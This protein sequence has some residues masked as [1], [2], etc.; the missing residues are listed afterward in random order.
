MRCN[1]LVRLFLVGVVSALPSGCPE[2][3][4]VPG[5]LD[6][7]QADIKTD[8]SVLDALPSDAATDTSPV[9]VD[10]SVPVPSGQA[11]AAIVD[12]PQHLITGPKADG[13]VGDVKILNARVAFIIEGLRRVDGYR[14]YGGNTVDMV[15][16]SEDG[17]QLYGDLFGE[18]VQ[19]WNLMIFEPLS[20]TVVD[21]GTSGGAARVRV[22][23]K[24]SPFIFADSFIRAFINPDLAELDIVHDYVLEPDVDYLRHEVRVANIGS[25]LVRIDPPGFL[26]NQGDGLFHF[27]RGSGFSDASGPVDYLAVGG[28]Q[29]AVGILTKDTT[30]DFAFNYSNVLLCLEENYSLAPGE[31]LL[32]TYFIGVSRNGHNGL[33]EIA[34]EL[35]IGEARSATIEGTV[36]LPS[37][38]S[39]DPEIMAQAVATVWDDSGPVTMAPI[40]ADGSFRMVV[41][42]G[43]YRVEVYVPQHAVPLAQDVDTTAGASATTTWSIDPA[44]LIKATIADGS[45]TPVDARVMAFADE[46]TPTPSP[47]PPEAV[48]V[49][50]DSSWQWGGGEFGRVSAV[51]YGIGG[52]TTLKVPAGTYVVHASRGFNYETD[53]EQVVVE[54]GVET[55]VALNISKVVDT[56]GTVSGDFHIHALRSPDSNVP[57]H[58]RALQAATVEMEAPPL[59][60]HVTLASLAPAIEAYGL[61]DHVIAVPGQEVTTFEFGHFNSFPLEYRELEPNNGAV[62]PYDKNPTT[63]FEAIRSQGTYQPFIQVNH[64]RGSAISGYFDYIGFDAVTGE[65]SRSGDAYSTNFDGIEVFNG[66]CG[67]SAEFDDW[68]AMTNLGWRKALSSG[69][70]SHNERGVI[71]NPRQVTF[72]EAQEVRS[73]LAVYAEALRKRRSFVT[74]GPFV[75][76][77]TVDE[78]A[79]MGDLAPVDND[80]QVA[81]RVQVS[82]PSW[83]TLTDVRL[84]RN[85]EVVDIVPIVEAAGGVRLDATLTDTPQADAWYMIHVTGSGDIRPVYNS[86]AP[87]AFTNPI[88][89]DAD[90]D[91]SWT[92]PGL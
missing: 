21:D 83:Q 3:P 28:A 66:S 2:D 71:G 22:E 62:F 24:A 59:T 39:D 38:A 50:G 91:G 16:L 72:V 43:S 5:P 68:V 92:P 35:T 46:S 79:G 60:E 55:A 65:S 54:A 42:P 48:D 31:E 4:S 36:T 29:Q 80:G 11:R 41:V 78:S 20:I 75:R 15:A 26:S 25:E 17:Q 19:T 52:N 7:P 47:Y 84:M 33:E 30:L 88:E 87:A 90:G 44:A 70:D 61:S 58:I 18:L 14:Y 1:T 85:G 40:E 32:R 56:V 76:F 77:H 53:S 12:D 74:C 23:G 6:A 37:T 13:Q 73:D 51:G 34:T 82:A 64:P 86:G 8:S 63:L 67:L 9:V 49:R 10:L 45:N 81:F 27:K 57:W 89:V 69:S